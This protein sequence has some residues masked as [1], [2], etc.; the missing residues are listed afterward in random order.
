[1]E[2]LGRLSPHCRPLLVWRKK[3]FKWLENLYIQICHRFSKTH[4]QTVNFKTLVVKNQRCFHQ[5]KTSLCRTFIRL[6]P[7][8]FLFI[9][10]QTDICVC[11][12]SVSSSRSGS[13]LGS[14][15]HFWIQERGKQLQVQ[16][17]LKNEPTLITFLPDS[18]L[19]KKKKSESALCSSGARKRK[20]SFFYDWFCGGC[21]SAETGF[22]GVSP[23][24][25]RKHTGSDTLVLHPKK[26]PI[27]PETA[28]IVLVFSTVYTLAARNIAS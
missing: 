28:H 26:K 21:S 14:R 20:I 3:W 25:L 5:N 10:A 7:V 9:H 23:F 1:M 8:Y 16:T 4:F 24:V 12:F 15:W 27:I 18:S 13:L 19:Q 22:N 2:V 6:S 11:P 17:I